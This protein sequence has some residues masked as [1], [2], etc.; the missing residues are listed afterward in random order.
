MQR[1]CG[2]LLLLVSQVAQGL[3]PDWQPALAG[4]EIARLD[5]QIGQWDRDYWLNG[6]SEV[7]DEVYDRLVA[8]LALWRQCFG[9]DT[10]AVA[11][12]PVAGTVLHPVAHTGAR[13]LKTR[14]AVAHWMAGKADLWIQPK[15]DGVAITLIYQAGKL[16]RAISRGDGLRG[17]DWTRNALQIAAIPKVVSG[18]LRDSVLQGELFLRHDGHI[19]QRMGGVNARAQVAGA[20][21]RHAPSALFERL[22]VFI[23]A[24]PDGPAHIM[25]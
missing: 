10:P 8:R 12:S 13:K 25:E 20:M 24:W 3:C 14:Q 2:L 15:V 7:S 21:M 5:Q 9:H 6:A 19:Q 1:W 4:Q 22:A 16:T 23:W 11:L 18:P 17:E